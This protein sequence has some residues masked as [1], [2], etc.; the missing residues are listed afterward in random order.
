LGK[1]RV[2]INI[3]TLAHALVPDSE[4]YQL[5][6]FSSPP[7]MLPSNPFFVEVKKKKKKK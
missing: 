4:S 7:K 2:N 5:E 6:S 1:Y 3:R